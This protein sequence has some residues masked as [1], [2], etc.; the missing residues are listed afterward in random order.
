MLFKNLIKIAIGLVSIAA[1]AQADGCKEIEKKLKNKID[2]CVT[3]G[4]FIE[5]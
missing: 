3:N 5:L 1:F 4:D 2:E